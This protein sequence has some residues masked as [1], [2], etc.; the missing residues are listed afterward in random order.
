MSGENEDPPVDPPVKDDP[1]TGMSVLAVD[2]EE[3][4]TGTQES[5]C[6]CSSFEIRIIVNLR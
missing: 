4:Q 2:S 5:G 3:G 6:R 1:K